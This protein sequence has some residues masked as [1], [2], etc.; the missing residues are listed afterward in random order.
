VVAGAGLAGLAAARA[1]ERDGARVTIVEA[2]DRVGGRVQT[3]RDGFRRRQHAEAG[4]DLIEGE[5]SFTRDLARDLGLKTTRIL[6]RGWGFYTCDRRGLRRVRAVSGIFENAARRLQPEIAAYRLADERWDSPIVA[7]IARRPVARWLADQ[8]AEPAFVRGIT[9]LRGFFLADPDDL[10][11]VAL[12]DQFAGGSPAA[13]E[14][15]RIVGGND[16]LATVLVRSLDARLLLDAA[17]RRI[18]RT[19]RGVRVTVE[20]RGRRS[21]LAADFAVVTLPATTLRSVRMEPGLPPPQA[22]AIATLRYGP[23]T[24]L[25]LQ[26]ERRWWKKED[27]PTAFGSDEPTGAIWDG[28]EEQR[29]APGILTFLAG[30]GA[31]A[32]LQRILRDEGVPGVTRRLE[33]LGRPATVL[34]ARTVAW[35]D[36][37]WVRGGYAYFDPGFD[38]GLRPWLARP[39]GRLVFAGEHT[40]TR[41][42]GYMNG[43]IESG[44]RAAAEVRAL[45]A[46]P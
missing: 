8:R 6:R 17:V 13:N 22:R 20:R 30:G 16:Q 9:G 33:W 46:E 27:R 23:A 43:A 29:G 25:V 31:S 19:S 42:Q 7:A 35:T 2:R 41:W 37:P 11:L 45:H 28:N 4:A 5:Q 34:A 21:E 18:V 44:L 3:L 40:A 1:L 38:P 36:D 10:S 32:A 26:F 14:T 15:F 39:A 12:V 24:R